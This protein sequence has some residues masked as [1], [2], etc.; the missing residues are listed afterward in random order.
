MDFNAAVPKSSCLEL[1]LVRVYFVPS[2]FVVSLNFAVV[3]MNPPFCQEIEL[4]VFW[5]FFWDPELWAKRNLPLSQ[6]G[7]I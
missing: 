3:T 7:V 5:G 4:L 6:P 1:L 2:W